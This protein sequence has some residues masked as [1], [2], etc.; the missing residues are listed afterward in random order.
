MDEARALALE[1]C[2]VLAPEHLSSDELLEM[3]T[4]GRFDGG[5]VRDGWEPL[6]G[7]TP[8]KRMYYEF[9]LYRPSPKCPYI[10]KYFARILVTRDR[11]SEAVHILWRPPVPEYHGPDFT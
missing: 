3:R 1:A 10:D 8:D 2:R 11:T 7:A 9:S 4:H 6:L 5:S